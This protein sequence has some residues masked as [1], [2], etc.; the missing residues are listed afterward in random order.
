M[1]MDA[2]IF[3]YDDNRKNKESFMTATRA[4]IIST[5]KFLYKRG[6]WSKY[7]YTHWMKE[8]EGIESEEMLHLW[9]DSIVSGA[10]FETEPMIEARLEAMGE[11]E[12]D[13][14]EKD[15]ME[16]RRKKMLKKFKGM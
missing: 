9:W 11:F 4:D 12:E 16:C 14:T 7:H 5:I 2:P 1:S 10:M 15:K 13:K 6:M 3:L 8:A